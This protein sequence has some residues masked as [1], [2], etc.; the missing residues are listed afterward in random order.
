MFFSSLGGGVFCDSYAAELNDERVVVKRVNVGTHHR[1][2]TRLDLQFIT[3]H[4]ERLQSVT[5]RYTYTDYTHYTHPHTPA[6]PN[7]IHPL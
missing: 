3:Q 1:R 6:T 5:P 4:I 7:L 2:L